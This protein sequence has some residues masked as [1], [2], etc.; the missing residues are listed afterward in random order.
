MT[1]GGIEALKAQDIEPVIK[2]RRNNRPD[3]SSPVKRRVVEEFL[4]LGYDG[5]AVDK[6]YGRRWMAETAFSA[7]K[8]LF[9]EQSAHP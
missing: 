7:F 9:G 3:T 5:W 6:G 1:P 8:R 4:D 2:P